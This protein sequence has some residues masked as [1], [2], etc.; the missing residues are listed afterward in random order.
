MEAFRNLLNSIGSF[1]KKIELIRDFNYFQKNIEKTVEL[2]TA[3]QESILTLY[4]ED[5]F[6]KTEIPKNFP[7]KI[8][9]IWQISKNKTLRLQIQ[10][11]KEYAEITLQRWNW[12]AMKYLPFSTKKLNSSI[13]VEKIIKKFTNLGAIL[14][15][16]ETKFT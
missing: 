8:D 12:D 10:Q 1:L 2:N 6:K 15:Y 14:I 11:E 7:Y 4:L 13:A 5:N 16:S 3:T 9:Q